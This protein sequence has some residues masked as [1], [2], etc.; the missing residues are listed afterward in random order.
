MAWMTGSG[1]FTASAWSAG[2][3]GREALISPALADE[4]NAQEGTTILVRV[5]RPDGHPA[6]DA[7]RPQG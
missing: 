6:R 1:S 3:E 7:A 5:Q 4:L 2:P